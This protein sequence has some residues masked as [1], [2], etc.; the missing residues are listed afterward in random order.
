MPSTAILS[1]YFERRRAL[2]EWEKGGP[3]ASQPRRRPPSTIRSWV[4][5]SV[6]VFPAIPRI[7][8]CHPHTIAKTA[9]P[10]RSKGDASDYYDVCIAGIPINLWATFN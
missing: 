7:A 10:L 4:L 8:G 9:T 3:A 6:A 1:Q 2:A 5:A